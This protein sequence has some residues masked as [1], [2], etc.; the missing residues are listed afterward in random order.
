MRRRP[1]MF[2]VASV[3]VLAGIQVFASWPA[4]AQAVV[5]FCQPGQPAAFVFG[6]ASLRDRLGATMGTPL[7][8]EHRDAQSG[9]TI[10]HTSTG[11]AYYR[12]SMN[13]AMFTDGATHWALTSST[14]VRW[15][16]DSVTPPQPTDAEAA[17]LQAISP[18]RSRVGTLQRRLNTARQQVERAQ[19]ASQDPAALRSLVD[20]LRTARDAY[21]A[22]RGAGRLSKYHAMMVVSLN[23][24]MGAA[25][26]LAQ[27]SQIESSDVRAQLVASA[28]KHGQESERLQA[29]A[30]EAYGKTLPVVVQ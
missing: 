21:V 18:L 19:A 5:P 29:A 13:T 15:Q 6:I 11:L 7:E 25:E 3:V 28:A 1:L 26:L 22:E 24:G 27:A 16:G 10:Q 12:P 17:Y 4:R 30:A 14:V 23:E 20:D 9:D 2:A 8:C